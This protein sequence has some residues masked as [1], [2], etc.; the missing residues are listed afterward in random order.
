MQKLG[1]DMSHDGGVARWTTAN[2]KEK[3]EAATEQRQS[4]ASAEGK[5]PQLIVAIEETVGKLTQLEEESA[6]TAFDT[7]ERDASASSEI[8]GI[9]K[10]MSDE[11]SKGLADTTAVDKAAWLRCTESS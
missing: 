8:V 2:A 4:I 7:C 9:L 3:F 1:H 5:S 6:E 10:T 11:M